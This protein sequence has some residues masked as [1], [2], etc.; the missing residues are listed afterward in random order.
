MD[1]ILP[2]PEPSEKDLAFKPGTREVRTEQKIKTAELIIDENEAEQ[3]FA[4]HVRRKYRLGFDFD[5]KVEIL[6]TDRS[7]DVCSV[8]ITKVVS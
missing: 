4:E 7:D 5:I 3:I 8:T 1:E 6:N 2:M